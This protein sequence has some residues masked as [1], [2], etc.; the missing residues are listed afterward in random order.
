SRRAASHYRVSSWQ[1]AFLSRPNSLICFRMAVP[2]ALTLY[3]HITTRAYPAS[4]RAIDGFNSKGRDLTRP[5]DFANVRQTLRREAHHA[6][7]FHYPGGSAAWRRLRRLNRV[8][9]DISR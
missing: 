7:P 5:A 2:F 3:Y 9:A 6:T 1:I 4:A 8:Y